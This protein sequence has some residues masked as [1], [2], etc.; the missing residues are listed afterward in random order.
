MKN[1]KCLVLMTLLSAANIFV[2]SIDPYES[3]LASHQ[4]P[5]FNEVAQSYRAHLMEGRY[6]Q[7]NPYS[8]I[9]PRKCTLGDELLLEREFH[10]ND[11]RKFIGFNAVVNADFRPYDEFLETVCRGGVFKG[12]SE[13]KNSFKKYGYLR[14]ADTRAND[15]AH[16]CSPWQIAAHMKQCDPTNIELNENLT[17]METHSHN[18][19]SLEKKISEEQ[20]VSCKLESVDKGML[21]NLLIVKEIR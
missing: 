18:L 13:V 21:I 20:G 4:K 19:G 2:A 1:F 12:N 10:G 3:F 9:N 5:L 8:G 6:A 16:Q 11:L 7:F 17:L 14:A 15:R